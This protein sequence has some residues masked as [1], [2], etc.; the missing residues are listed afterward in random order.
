ML[1]SAR[2]S[3][4]V[5]VDGARKGPPPLRRRIGPKGLRCRA[6]GPGGT[7]GPARALK[8]TGDAA[9]AAAEGAL[10]RAG[11]FLGLGGGENE[12]NDAEARGARRLLIKFIGLAICLPWLVSTTL[13]VA[14]VAPT[15]RASVPLSSPL[16]EPSGKQQD[17]IATKCGNLYS[18]W[19]LPLPVSPRMPLT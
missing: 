16:F 7:F 13:R 4:G 8:Q 18:A 15:V 3:L 17:E 1:Q 12:E 10:G 9:T 19:T 5:K 14:F 11:R 6:V 2:T